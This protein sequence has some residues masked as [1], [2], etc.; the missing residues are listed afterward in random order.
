MIKIITLSI[1]SNSLIFLSLSMLTSANIANVEN[2][3][4]H[5]KVSADLL[6]YNIHHF[7]ISLNIN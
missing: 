6:C 2:I 3:E 4:E 1:C 5:R 7:H